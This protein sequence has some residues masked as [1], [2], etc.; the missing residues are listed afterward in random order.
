MGL[1]YIWF[2]VGYTLLY[3][4]REK[5]YQQALRDFGV[6][7]ALEDLDRGFH[8][9]DKYFMREHR[10]I[11]LNP[12]ETY[13]P[14]YLGR[15]NRHLGIAVDI[16]SLDR[17]WQERKMEL[18]HYWRPFERVREVLETLKERPLGIGV[19]S[20]WD[21]TARHVL[22]QT[23]LMEIF[24]HVIISSECGMAKPDAGIFSLALESAGVSAH[25]CL[26]VG[27]NYY[28]DALG[29]RSVGM[30]AV[31]VNRFGRMGIEEIEE[32][33]PIIEHISQ[34]DAYLD[35][36]AAGSVRDREDGP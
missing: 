19:I 4:E 28:D 32:D 34:I 18:Q 26:Y 21:E 5:P 36:L 14:W 16:C 22:Q 9:T 17:R 3:M 33:I 10:G 31:I 29:S 23:G 8:L 25:E 6:E 12:R 13:M 35:R 2:D 1:S 20:N 27:D 24:D 30:Q 7:I 11:F 15:L